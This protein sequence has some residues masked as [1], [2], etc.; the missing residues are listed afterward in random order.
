MLKALKFVQMGVSTHGF[1]DTLTHFKI[2]QGMVTGS[3]GWMTIQAPIGIDITALPKAEPFVRAIA[4]CAGTV[5]LH[6]T[7][8][9]KLAVCSDGFK[10]F[11]D[12]LSVDDFPDNPSLDMPLYPINGDFLGLLKLLFPFILDKEAA[13][14]CEWA[15][16]IYVRKDGCAIATNNIALVQ[17]FVGG[18]V[19]LSE[20]ITIPHHVVKE[21]LRIGENPQYIGYNSRGILFG[22]SGDR[23]MYS[24]RNI[25]VFPDELEQVFQGPYDPQP[26]PEELYSTLSKIK[27]FLE[28]DGYVFMEN[29]TMSTR[30]VEGA[31]T[32]VSMPTCTFKANFNH[33]HLSALKNVAALMD[34]G[35]WPDKACY[36]VGDNLRGVIAGARPA[37]D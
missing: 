11:V 28:D 36:F 27:P 22:Y 20:N 15:N 5:S 14:G 8:A 34:F 23:W 33:K 16:S 2:S 13:A 25:V 17:K 32:V 10:S 3:N 29:G 1:N 37:K 6:V 12:C 31:G 26:L 9:G 19:D 21:V 18:M 24:V 30:S 7:P 4:A 35:P